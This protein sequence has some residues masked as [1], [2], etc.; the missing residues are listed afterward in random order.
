MGRLLNKPIWPALL[1]LVIPAGHYLLVRCNVWVSPS[2][3]ETKNL[4]TAVLTTSG[5]LAS[6]A[7][8]IIVFLVSDRGATFRNVRK[9]LSSSFV[10]QTVGLFA[11]PAVAMF[12]AVSTEIPLLSH[13]VIWSLEWAICLL[14]IGAV[15]DFLFLYI[16]ANAAV[17]QDREDEGRERHGKVRNSSSESGG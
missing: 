7:G 17:T 10:P 16:C 12:I 15:Y 1:S 13:F 14:I 11:L 2:F 8:V 3:P 4:A 9:K 5:F 6:M